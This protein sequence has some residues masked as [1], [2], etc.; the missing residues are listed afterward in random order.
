MAQ[1]DCFRNGFLF[2]STGQKQDRKHKYNL[3]IVLVFISMRHCFSA[4]L[5]KMDN[6]EN[7]SI[8][9]VS[10][11]YERRKWYIPF[12]FG[13]LQYYHKSHRAQQTTDLV[14]THTSLC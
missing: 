7:V 1:P 9:E 2:M 12:S 5:Q 10:G 3:K 13:N 6:K 14:Y 8:K 11:L 4:M